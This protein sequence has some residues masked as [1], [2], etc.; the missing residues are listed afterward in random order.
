MTYSYADSLASAEK[1]NWKLDDVLA[2][3]E[4]FDY[5]RPFLPESLA[6]AS[7]FDFLST[8]E[9]LVLNQI[10]GHAYLSMFGLIEEC[11]LPFV[12]DH[13]RPHLDDDD[14][15]TRALLQFAGEEAKHIQLFKRF[16]ETFERG[17]RTRSPRPSSPTTLSASRSSSFMSNG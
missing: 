9:A 8:D 6:R 2:P 16:K 5:G 4:G 13:A 12:L 15:R 7:G 10:R 14:W 1:I 11:I 17:R 3:G